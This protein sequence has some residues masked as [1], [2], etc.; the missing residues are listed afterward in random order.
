MS[1]KTIAV[2]AVLAFVMA[3]AAY[4]DGPIEPEPECPQMVEESDCQKPNPNI[5]DCGS[6]VAT[7]LCDGLTR[8][9]CNGVSSS[10]RKSHPDG[11]KDSDSGLTRTKEE[12]CQRTKS[13]EWK[14]VPGVF[15]DECGQSDWTAWSLADKVVVWEGCDCPGNGGVA[16]TPIGGHSVP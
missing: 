3:I 1:M 11:T 16:P 14:S 12:Q 13:C 10:Q 6:P 4:A 15:N 5:K 2:T 8:E 9:A 7:K